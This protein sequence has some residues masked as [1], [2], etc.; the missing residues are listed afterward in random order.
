[1]ELRRTSRVENRLM[2]DDRLAY[3]GLGLIATWAVVSI[4]GVALWVY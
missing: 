4:V 2:R 3:V 1:M